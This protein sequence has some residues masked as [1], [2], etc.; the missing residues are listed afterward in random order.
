MF[1]RSE[2]YKFPAGS[3][4]FASTRFHCKA[5]L[6]S[7]SAC[8]R[9][10]FRRNERRVPSPS[11][12]DREKIFDAFTHADRARRHGSLGL[13][14]SL[15]RAIVAFPGGFGT[16]DELFE[17]LTLSQTHKLDRPMLILLY[18]SEYWNE[19]VNFEALARHG[20]IAAQ[21]LSL[22]RLTDTVDEALALLQRGLA[23]EIEAVTP[24]FARSATGA[25][26]G[27]R[28]RR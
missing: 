9:R 24:A 19:I 13:G 26:P 17:L 25:R 21:D 8:T 4:T 7:T 6:R 1:D 18:G 3:T 14:P 12:A 16:L 22:F 2:K 10:P 15:A 5:P 27:A 28:S 23:P 11:G 20:M